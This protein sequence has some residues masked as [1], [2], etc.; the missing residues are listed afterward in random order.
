MSTPRPSTTERAQTPPR[1]SAW[2][3]LRWAALVAV[4]A[5]FAVVFWLLHSQSGT[6]FILARVQGAL[7]GKLEIGSYSGTLAGPFQLDGLRY[8]DPEAGIDARIDRIEVDPVLLALVGKELDFRT[9]EVDGVQLALTSV[10]E[11]PDKPKSEF[12]LRAP[13]D[14]VVNQLALKN[15]RIS[16]DGE[17]VLAIDSLDLVAGWTASG[18]VVRQLDLRSPDGQIALNGSLATAKGY[19]GSGETTFNWKLGDVAVA[20]VL[21]STSNGKRAQLKLDLTAPTPASI[22]MGIAQTRD[23]AWTLQLDA[24]AFEAKKILPES[25]LG[26]LALNLHGSGKR[27]QGSLQGNVTINEH[28]VELDPLHYAL[29]DG[30]LKIESLG[31]RSPASPGTFELSGDV[32]YAAEPVSANLVASWQGVE[33]PADLVGQLLATRGRLEIQGDLAGFDARGDLSIGPPGQLSDIGIDIHGTE[34]LINLNT[35]RLTQ[36]TGGLEAS[37]T[38]TLQPTIGWQISAVADQLDPGAFA[39]DWPGALDFTLASSGQLTDQGPSAELKL[40]SL[41]GRLR[42]RPISG[43]ADLSMDPGYVVDGT[44]S[45]NSGD[46]TLAIEGK[47]GTSTDAR[48]RFDLAS[49]ADFLPD[50]GG[51]VNGNFHVTGNWPQLEI[52]GEARGSDLSMAGVQISSAEL[53][54]RV[55][56]L[57]SPAGALTL[58]ASNFSRGGIQFD[59]LTLEAEGNKSAHQLK[60][61]ADGT[62]ADFSLGVK[63]AGDIAGWKGQLESLS[64]TPVRRNAPQLDL[65]RP[66]EMSW[67]GVRF[68]LEQSCLIGHQ[69]ER[70]NRPEDREEASPV[71]AEEANRDKAESA[72]LPARICLGGDFGKDGSLAANYQLEHLPLRLLLRLAAPDSPV[73]LRGELTGEGDISKTA[74]G[75][76]TG[77]ARI[78]SSEGRLF[79]SGESN[80]PVL[81]YTDFNVTANLASESTVVQVRA[82]LDND[83]RIDGNLTMNPV[84]AGSPV[85]NGTL[86]IDLNSLAFLELITG[87]LSNTQGSVHANYTIAGT[88]DAPRLDGALNLADF[89]TEVPTAGLKLSKGSV[90]LR[91]TDSENFAID[92][93]LTS[94]A[95]TLV[96]AG[97]GELAAKAPLKLTIKGE[98]F[99][100]ADIPAARVVISPD[101]SIERTTEGI[102]VNGKVVIPAADVDLAKLPGG[103]TSS[104]SADVVIV[105]ADEPAPAKA[106]PITAKVTVTLGEKVKLTG[107]GFDGRIV[108][109]I[110]V[111]DRPGRVTTANGA[112]DATGTYY[113]YGQNLKIETGRILFANTPIDNPALDIRAVRRIESESITA[114]LN[115]RGTAQLPVLTVFSVPARDNADAL[116]YLMTGKALAGGASFTFGRYLSPKLYLS[117]GV[118][119]F[120]PGE[121]VT[122]RYLFNPSWNFEAVNATEGSRAG[123]NYRIEK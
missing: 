78:Q 81:S 47:G 20:G 63:G 48:V 97:T 118:G 10:P 120:E 69:Q 19:S 82:S 113:A 11:D 2:R 51:K 123:I 111:S 122:L 71:A 43:S 57:E 102:F 12:S 66:A 29:T 67:D 86:K 76:L 87:E 46:S 101:L 15:A 33:L 8:I 80:Q 88:L 35:V 100:A 42:E 112:L 9:I 114:G 110:A 108:G 109:E 24:P 26:T 34:Q 56:N 40:E 117:Y 79:F 41:N 38:I 84:E 61:V 32:G 65:S 99:L 3:W 96:I 115:V 77:Q 37:G 106:L 55:E 116:S 53:V 119:I 6:G 91:A 89:A 98:D 17:P 62:P 49:L 30:A 68:A 74:D 94:G 5:L 59:T 45:I 75:L 72:E 93:S 23:A 92:G 70:R 4:V 90:R 1:R 104:A 18:I 16:Q 58:K 21:K 105:D 54:T 52:D 36:A 31:L 60:L 25:T 22:E 7:D 44:L 83:G 39:A 121:V 14:I 103:G 64:L 85:L 28:R 107:F 13:I 27:D 95:G 73:R 50:S